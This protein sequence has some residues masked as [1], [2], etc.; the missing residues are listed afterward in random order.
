MTDLFAWT[1]LF[2]RNTGLPVTIW[3][4]VDGRVATDPYHLNKIE[5]AKL[6]TAWRRLNSAALAAH[7]RGEIDG[8]EM[9]L[10]SQPVPP[11]LTRAQYLKL[12]MEREDLPGV[13]IVGGHVVSDRFGEMYGNA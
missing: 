13:V 1:N 4:S 8:A 3:V 5:H 2:P 6:V 12:R 10:R 7:W 11:E 9:A